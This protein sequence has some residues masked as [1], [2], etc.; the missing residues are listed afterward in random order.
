MCKYYSEYSTI[1]LLVYRSRA[2]PFLKEKAICN[3]MIFMI[4]PNIILEISFSYTIKILIIIRLSIFILG[5]GYF[6]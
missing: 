2:S 5:R 6:T 4:I 1:F 3:D